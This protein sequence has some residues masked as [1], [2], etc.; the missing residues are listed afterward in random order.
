MTSTTE[1][2]KELISIIVNYNE[3]M[4]ENLKEA[5]ENFHDKIESDTEWKEKQKNIWLLVDLWWYQ[6]FTQHY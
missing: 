5:L 1:I 6:Y 2:K 4:T 3:Q